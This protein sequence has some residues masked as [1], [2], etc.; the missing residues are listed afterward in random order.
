[1][2]TILNDHSRCV[3]ASGLFEQATTKEV[4]LV[5][6]DAVTKVGVPKT[7]VCDNGS[8]FTCSEFKR[9]CKSIKL[10]ID[11]APKHYPQYKGMY[12]SLRLME[13]SIFR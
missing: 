12:L 9:V 8:Q 2:I 5:L 13:N 11:Y 6:K 3:V 1:M 4:V 10:K 7:I